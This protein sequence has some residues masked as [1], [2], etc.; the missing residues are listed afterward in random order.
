MASSLLSSGSN[1]ADQIQTTSSATTATSAG[2][3]A[4]SA[5]PNVSPDAR[6]QQYGQNNYAGQSDGQ[7]LFQLADMVVPGSH[8]ADRSA[9]AR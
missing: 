1:V 7:A 5:M 9:S 4:E 8:D 3:E 2:H 6:S